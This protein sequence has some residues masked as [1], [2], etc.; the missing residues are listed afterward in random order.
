M[1]QQG[2]VRA[3][4]AAAAVLALGI[5]AEAYYHYT[6]YTGHS[7]PFTPV[8]A[9]FNLAALSN[10]TLNVFV[11]DAGPVNYAANDTFGSVLGEVKQAVAAWNTVPNSAL[12]MNFAGLESASQIPQ[13][14]GSA[15]SAQNTPAIDVVFVEMPPGLLGYGSPNIPVVPQFETGSDGQPM[16]AITRSVAA[17]TND[18]TLGAGLSELPDFFTTAVH[19]IGHA[20]GLQHTWTGAAMSQGVIRNTTR[21]RPID[22]D[23]MAAFNTLYGAPN[24]TANYGSISGQVTFAG[25]NTGVNLASVVALPVD[26]GPA[27]SALTDPAG[28]YN[29]GGLPVGP[30]G[31]SYLVFVHPLPPDAFP[32]DAE[33][34]WG[35]YDVNGLRFAPS[36][37][38][39]TVFYPGATDEA[40]ATTFSVTAGAI[41]TANFSVAPEAKVPMYDVVT[42]GFLDPSTRDYTV[43]LQQEYD[44]MSPAFINGTQAESLVETIYSPL[45]VPQS[46]SLLGG[47]APAP[48]CT[49]DAPCFE[50]WSPASALFVYFDA[51][52][53][54]G[55]GLRHL[56]FNL[57][58]DLYV[59]PAGVNLVEK[60]PPY[61]D[62]VTGNPDGTVTVTGTG[63]GPDSTVYFDSLP[64]SVTTS[65]CSGITSA[66]CTI[67]VTPPSGASGQTSDITVFNAD[68]QDSTFLQSANL[69]VYSYP[70]TSA[71]Q[72]QTVNP[73]SLG[74]GGEAMVD[75]TASN[76]SF[77]AG[78]VTV[79][80]GTSDITVTG[81]WVISPTHVVANVVVAPGATPGAWEISM[82]SGFQVMTQ[83]LGIQIVAANPAGPAILAVVNGVASQATIYPGAVITAWGA[84]LANPQITIIPITS[85]TTPAAFAGAPAQIVYS[86]GD[87]VNV[88]LP[89]GM[90]IG[91]AMLSL[92]TGAG[93]T[94]VVVPIAYAPPVILGIAEP[95]GAIVN[96]TNAA[97]PGDLLRIAI[98]G[99]DPT[100]TLAS[101]RLQVMVAGVS[102]PV[103]QIGASQIQFTLNQSFNGTEVPV[104][105]VVDGSSSAA[106]TILAN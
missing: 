1:R 37:D 9:R 86:S 31:T 105:I 73:P 94:S 14:T 96:S 92:T 65:S 72:L 15:Q 23:D 84:N 34:I 19:E 89:V 25:R 41:F 93:T 95:S 16:V 78:Q 18:T 28:F 66:E 63:L 83:P 32:A 91:P 101:G 58:D 10:N 99:L 44:W 6:Y 68:G 64:A 8:H 20:L 102:M 27:V 4:V 21:V 98:S 57:N 77:V 26:G 60:Q 71:P 103:Q 54:A 100:V 5:P 104:T 75:I 7:A 43:N 85:A 52:A 46:V 50:T 90:P 17:L 24:W 35:P 88:A 11:S 29:I 61:V 67:T 42:R 74:A 48:L 13:P 62:S 55:S 39:R 51:P 47:F 12:R 56:I 53:N 59:L 33:G 2:A 79:G 38:F 70:A 87:Q 45:V 40:S 82:I 97:S 22:A 106:F 3:V 30:A 80:F 81:V 36:G 76:T 49:T 69:P